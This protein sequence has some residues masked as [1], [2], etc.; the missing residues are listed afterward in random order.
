M[1]FEDLFPSY[2]SRMEEARLY[3]EQGLADEAAEV[4]E[5]ISKEMEGSGLSDLQKLDLRE[6][7]QSDLQTIAGMRDSMGPD[8]AAAPFRIGNKPNSE[9][10]PETSAPSIGPDAPAGTTDPAQAF[11]YGL[12]L[13]DSQF[14]E[15]AI[16]EFRQAEKSGYKVLQCRELCGDCAVHLERWEDALRWYEGIYTIQEIP[17]D[18][19][20]RLLIKITRCSQTQKKIDAK[21]SAHARLQAGRY[22]PVTQEESH[23]S[24]T[25]YVAASLTSIDQ[26]SITQLLGQ[27]VES[28]KGPTGETLRGKTH[29]Y[30]ISNLLHVGITSQVLEL[31][32]EST[33]EHLAGQVIASPYN[34][35]LT[36][37]TVA[38]WA[39]TQMMLDSPHLVRIHD[40]ACS[41]NI[42]LIVRQYLPKSLGDLLA[43][44]V[45]L[46]IP[47][48][49]HFAHQVLEG[50][51]DLHL[52]MGRDGSIR[53]IFHLDL[54]PS[55]VLY[56]PERGRVRINNGGL[57]KLLEECN[58]QDTSVKSLPLPFLAY[59]APEQFRPYLSRRRP[60]VFTDT[61][62][63]GTLFYEMLTGIP[64]FWASSAEEY[65]I[66]HCDQYPAPPKVWRS[67]IPD[68]INNIIM[69]CLEVDPMKRWRSITQ[70]SLILEKTFAHA[71]HL[72]R[73]GSFSKYLQRSKLA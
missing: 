63:F 4:L 45:V 2:L 15:E 62:L 57:W 48:A 30:R 25:D 69:K 52:H 24:S 37:A 47:L 46:P 16:G 64:P 13:M 5:T 73:D 10:E 50:L 22:G 9:P 32:L 11:Q 58:P 72:E 33:G 19:K 7:I 38:K 28:W 17:D 1:A 39:R 49:I 34:R 54:R 43:G 27:T 36:P 67:E 65:E 44:G 53:N 20:Q 14:W 12:A 21:S 66:Q 51:G 26:S 59:R 8:L 70:I 3:I 31:A 42:I 40:V 41:E 6:R 29:S 61:Y 56:H 18:L 55:R 23:G 35:A 68:E 71:I 60:P